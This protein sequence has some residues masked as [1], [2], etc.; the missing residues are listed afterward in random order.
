MI[1]PEW[2][3]LKVGD[4]VPDGPDFAAYF[5]VMEVRQNEAIVY[6]SIRHPY[7]GQAVDPNDAAAVARREGELIAGGLY[8]DFT[9]TFTLR[10]VGDDATRLFVRAR[11]DLHPRWLVAMETIFGLV[12]LFPVTTMFRG[13]KRRSEAGTRP[14]KVRV[15][16]T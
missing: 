12:D 13:I 16:T 14:G 2:Q 15:R 11:S 10:P 1:L 3:Q 8:L 4:I 9:W 6:H 7:R 5:R